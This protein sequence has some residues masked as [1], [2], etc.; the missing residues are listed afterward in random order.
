MGVQAFFGERWMFGHHVQGGVWLGPPDLLE[1][2]DHGRPVLDLPRPAD[3]EEARLAP[4]S[5][6]V[7]SESRVVAGSDSIADHVDPFQRE[8]E[9]PVPTGGGG[10]EVDTREAA[11]PPSPPHTVFPCGGLAPRGPQ[12]GP[13]KRKG[14]VHGRFSVS[15]IR[16]G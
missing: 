2:G 16:F 10:R 14:S 9:G 4:G 12:A 3:E 5:K 13:T 7:R 1:G 15:P 11:N 6:P 8:V